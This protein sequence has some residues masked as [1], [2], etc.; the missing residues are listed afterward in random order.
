MA[1]RTKRM[2]V[3]GIMGGYPMMCLCGKEMSSVPTEELKVVRTWACRNW[4]CTVRRATEMPE[5]GRTYWH[6]LDPFMEKFEV[7]KA[8]VIWDEEPA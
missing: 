3:R 1:A 7:G 5:T 4:W 8:M 6:G 2:P